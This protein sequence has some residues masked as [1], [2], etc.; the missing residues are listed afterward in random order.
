MAQC[1][2]DL[3]SN[4][5][6]MNYS[7]PFNYIL[8]NRVNISGDDLRAVAI[9]LCGGAVKGVCYLVSSLVLGVGLRPGT[10]YDLQRL[11]QL[12]FFLISRHATTSCTLRAYV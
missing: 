8:R 3:V 11:S 12:F 1:A 9:L 2:K 10:Q 5:A 6:G 4:F 7:R